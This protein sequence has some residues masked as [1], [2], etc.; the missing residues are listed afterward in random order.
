M[1]L[2]DAL[3]GPVVESS[4]QFVWAWLLSGKLKAGSPVL[5]SRHYYGRVVCVGAGADLTN[6]QSV[7]KM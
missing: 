6:D 7:I 3:K 1:L 4:G 2:K 5:D